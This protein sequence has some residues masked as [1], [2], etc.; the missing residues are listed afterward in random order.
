VKVAFVVQRCGREVNGGAET[1]CL[2]VARRMARHWQTEIL[3]TCALDYV[4]WDNHYPEGT[5]TVE[6]IVIRRFRVDAP[7][8]MAQFDKLSAQL[9]SNG[10]PVSLEK[11]EEW[12][13]AQGPVSTA[14]FQYLESASDDYDAFIF[15][16]YLY[17]TTYFGL[18]VV[19]EKAYLAPLGH[20]EWPIYF[21]MWDKFFQ[22]PKG[23]IFQTV[24]EREFLARRFPSLPLLGQVAGIGVECPEF[25]DPSAFRTK[26]HLQQPFLL[27]V[28]RIDAS[29]GCAEMFDAFMRFRANATIAHKLVLIGKEA[30]PV[31]YHEDIVYLGFV[32]EEEKW[33]AMAA[34]D[35]LL[36]PSP[37]ESLSIVLL[38]TWR[39]ARPAIVNAASEVLLGHCRRSNGG[40]WYET[41]DECAAILRGIDSATK[42]RLGQ[43][44]QRYVKKHY[45]WDRT[46]SRYLDALKGQN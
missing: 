11:Q 33:N 9:L 13:R 20:D 14:L 28:G 19:K 46:E 21:S 44:G 2:Q 27:Y 31:P 43:Q 23:L 38:E 16:G 22:L 5:E 25:V 10:G 39:V 1:L 45:A 32:S 42:N 18:P 15:F 3:T 37:Y 41:W 4:R 34:C 8:D 26:Y 6:G 24:E 35:W 30:L 7:R 40:L 29:K 17:A 36:M 12:M